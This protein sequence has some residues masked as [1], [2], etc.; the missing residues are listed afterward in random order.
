VQLFSNAYLVFRG[1]ADSTASTNRV[2]RA[3]RIDRLRAGVV[4]QLTDPRVRRGSVIVDAPLGF[5]R[6]T[7]D[8]V[9]AETTRLEDHHLDAER[10]YLLL[11]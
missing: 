3:Y 1:F 8:S 7:P 4:A 9:S 6:R 11:E 2:R 5:V 10:F